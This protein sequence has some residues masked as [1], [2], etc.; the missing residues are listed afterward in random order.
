MIEMEALLVCVGY[1]DYLSFTITSNIK[2][3]SRYV[4]VTESNDIQTQ[5]VCEKHGATCVLSSRR[6]HNGARFNKGAL[7]N[8]GIRHLALDEWVAVLDS[9]IILPNTF[10]RTCKNNLNDAGCL[11]SCKRV[12]CDTI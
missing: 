2:Y 1:G 10:E 5:S 8:D 3:F 4:I 6:H 11:Y 12:Q 9:D 7:L